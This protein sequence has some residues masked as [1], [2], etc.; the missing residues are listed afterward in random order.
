MKYKLINFAIGAFFLALFV[1]AIGA[2]FLSAALQVDSIYTVATW[3]MGCLFLLAD[4]VIKDLK[5]D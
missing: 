4:M 1:F 2:S 3:F 5:N